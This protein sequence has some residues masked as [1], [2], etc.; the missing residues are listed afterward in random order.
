MALKKIE[1]YFVIELIVFS[2]LL[3]LLKA[4]YNRLFCLIIK[5]CLPK[6]KE[7]KKSRNF[8]LFFFLVGLC[9]IGAMIYWTDFSQIQWDEMFEK[10]PLA[11]C[12]IGVLWLTNY[13]LY[14]IAYKI[15]IGKEIK[16][17]TLWHNYMVTLSSFA[18]NNVTPVGFIGG[19]PYRIMKMKKHLGIEEATSST[20]TFTIMTTIAHFIFWMFGCVLYF[21]LIG[22]KDSVLW[23]V[24]MA[25]SL[26]FCLFVVSSFLFSNK[27]N[28][29]YKIISALGSWPFIGKLVTK[30]RL[31]NGQ[32]IK[33]ID[34]NIQNFQQNPVKF[35]TVLLLA[36]LVR[37][38]EGC[39]L[40]VILSIL[41]LEDIT[42]IKALF[43]MAMT[44][45]VGNILFI[46]PMQLGVR[47][48]GAALA[49]NWLGFE[50]SLGMTATLMARIREIFFT[51]LGV[52]V[53][54]INNRKEET[55][56][57]K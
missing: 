14:A 15:I 30:F 34:K 4:L 55:E 39:E 7:Y 18:L 19:E 36:F 22:L 5:T 21:I 24:I 16:G 1:Y 47:E 26:V 48:G 8:Q 27:S 32:K 40:Y 45:F 52:V 49:L 51:L 31:K 25:L 35:I 53:I 12:T 42:I 54:L 13:L 44:S 28:F 23:S 33:E 50:G 11:I 56:E 57:N 20:I 29:S 10:L 43:A 2:L 6:E 41:G 3:L 38:L 17:F 37:V 9:G 46:I